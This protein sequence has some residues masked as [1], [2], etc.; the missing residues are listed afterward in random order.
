MLGVALPQGESRLGTAVL[1][2]TSYKHLLDNCWRNCNSHPGAWHISFVR[3]VVIV[4]RVELKHLSV[5]GLSRRFVLR[6][7]LL[8]GGNVTNV[9][10]LVPQR[11]TELNSSHSREVTSKLTCCAQSVMTLTFTWSRS[12]G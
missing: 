12:G 8:L 5:V 10:E 6:Q 3:G 7:N 1:M 2:T 11:G 4:R 9:E